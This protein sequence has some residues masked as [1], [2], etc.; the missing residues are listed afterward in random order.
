MD[1]LNNTHPTFLWP[2]KSTVTFTTFKILCRGTLTISSW[3]MFTTILA[4]V[5]LELHQHSLRIFAT[6]KLEQ[7]EPYGLSNFFQSMPLSTPWRCPSDRMAT[8]EYWP[9]HHYRSIS[10]SWTTLPLHLNT[11]FASPQMY[12]VCTLKTKIAVPWNSLSLSGSF[13]E[14]HVSD[15]ECIN[16]SEHGRSGSIM[17][18]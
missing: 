5:Q 1:K 11:V 16:F 18:L 14:L 10:E 2:T 13:L 17:S 8:R 4:V 6:I 15:D 12:L 3:G 9:P 7:Y